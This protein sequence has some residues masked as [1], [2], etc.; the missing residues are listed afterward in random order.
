MPGL[1]HKI[2]ESG[3]KIATKA[4]IGDILKV[5]LPFLQLLIT[6]K[7]FVPILLIGLLGAGV[8]YDKITG[9]VAAIIGGLVVVVLLLTRWVRNRK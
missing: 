4:V 6:A 9:D 5:A 7:I 2:V 1:F 8:Y 3:T